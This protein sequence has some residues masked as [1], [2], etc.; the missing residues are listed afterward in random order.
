MG[1]FLAAVTS[2]LVLAGCGAASASTSSDDGAGRTSAASPAAKAYSLAAT[3]RCLSRRNV[4]VTPVRRADARRTAFAQLAQRNSI[5]ARF[6][7]GWVAVAFEQSRLD[8]LGLLE[9][10]RLPSDPY[11]LEVVGSAVLLSPRARTRERAIV[12]GCLR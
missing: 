6:A 9:A 1:Q 12:V 4:P 10:L 11:R 5:Q 2:T 3:S 8:A 7:R